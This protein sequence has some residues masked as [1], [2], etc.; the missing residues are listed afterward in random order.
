ML[1][2]H[3]PEAK[4]ITF[5][6][7]LEDLHYSNI[8]KSFLAGICSILLLYVVGFFWH[9]QLW[10]VHF[11]RFLKDEEILALLLVSTAVAL[12]PKEL[13]ER[14]VSVTKP[15]S[16][17]ETLLIGLVIS[18]AYGVLV[19]SFA[20]SSDP[21]G[22][23]V[24]FQEHLDKVASLP[25]IIY[26][27][28]F[29]F[30]LDAWSGENSVLALVSLLSHH[31]NI[32]H[33]ETFKLLGAVSAVIFSLAW[34]VYLHLNVPKKVVVIPLFLVGLLGPYT[35]VFHGHAEIYAPAIA[36][37]MVWVLVIS[38][39]L[40]KRTVAFSL[41]VFFV[42]LMVLKLHPIGVMLL[43]STILI[44]LTN[45]FDNW[46]QTLQN[47]RLILI[48][49]APAITIGLVVYFFVLGDHLDNRSLQ[50][51]A[52]QY[53]HLFLPLFSP[54]PPLHKYNLFSLN[55][56]L[57]FLNVVLM[58]S[59]VLLLILI[60]GLAQRLTEKKEL[61]LLLVHL[62]LTLVLFFLL[63]F[64]IN[65]LLSMPMDWDLFML[66]VPVLLG[67]AIAGLTSELQISVM[68]LAPLLVG[69]SIISLSFIVS[70]QNV[71]NISDRLRS[72]AIH[73]HDTYYEWTMNI[74][75]RS[76]SISTEPRNVQRAKRKVLR[77]RLRSNAQGIDREFS[78][79]LRQDAKLSYKGYNDLDAAKKYLDEAFRYNPTDGNNHVTAV[80]LNFQLKNMEQAFFHGQELVKMEF[81][82]LETS[83][84]IAIH[85][86]IEAK[87]YD[88][89]QDL[90]FRYLNEFE[91]ES[92]LNVYTRLVA[93]NDLPSLKYLF[94][95]SD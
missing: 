63:L 51:T 52:K 49:L 29:G 55:H 88:K 24:R 93:K 3:L 19:Y 39:A 58:G 95:R 91:D 4:L 47:G 75:D 48:V 84:R 74:S 5:A 11:F 32:T 71:N 76:F 45:L 69:V 16:L 65:P 78:E 2:G 53:D 31:F 6:F 9:E 73:V 26:D 42:N 12:I 85:C 33:R 35:L 27:Y 82:D 28:L 15:I 25:P 36:M 13:I 37:I 1:S 23:S 34:F 59:P 50:I 94:Q 54:E 66:F 83:L 67:C 62:L 14:L 40:E 38:V 18:V 43:P 89:A 8:T 77:E 7:I 21:Y 20:I 68:R 61:P 44:F 80:E 86:A 10:G 70:S 46:F 92:I 90:C 64:A 57:D 30:S 81:P 41:L 87:Y 56:I 72:I 79:F 17:S 60:L 22:D